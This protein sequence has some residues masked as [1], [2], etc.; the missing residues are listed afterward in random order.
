MPLPTL[1]LAYLKLKTAI[2]AVSADFE[3]LCGVFDDYALFI[4]VLP[5]SL[6]EF[7]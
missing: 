3:R 7:R 1:K 2:E 4:S 6:H 5:V